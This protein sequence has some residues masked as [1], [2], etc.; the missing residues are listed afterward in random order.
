MGMAII[1]MLVIVWYVVRQHYLLNIVLKRPSSNLT[2][3]E[4]NRL[5]SLQVACVESNRN[6]K[7]TC[8]FAAAYTLS[9]LMTGLPLGVFTLLSSPED[10]SDFAIYFLIAMV[11]SSGI[12]NMLIFV[13]EKVYHRM[14]VD[15]NLTFSRALVKIFEATSQEPA[16]V[17][18]S[19]IKIVRNNRYRD[20][21]HDREINQILVESQEEEEYD[22]GDDNSAGSMV[23]SRME[24]NYPLSAVSGCGNMN[25]DDSL[26]VTPPVSS[27]GVNDLPQ[28]FT[29]ISTPDWSSSH[30]F[31][32]PGGGDHSSGRSLSSSLLSG[33][34]LNSLSERN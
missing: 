26:S 6:V 15:K 17:M 22:R 1:S 19:N 20:M 16:D 2:T 12:S 13:A 3:N 23:E 7:H 4:K 8:I 28:E 27:R 10:A 25:D 11:P 24:S 31:S 29:I 30:P 5:E 9:C 21:W 34:L 18:F 32:I 33:V 14:R